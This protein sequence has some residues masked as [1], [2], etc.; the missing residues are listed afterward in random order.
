MRRLLALVA[1]LALISPTSVGAVDASSTSFYVRQNIHSISGGNSQYS[2]STSTSFQLVSA[3]GQTANGTS[4]VTT[5]Y[6]LRAGFLQSLFKSVQPIYAQTHYHWRLDNGTES[7]ATALVAEDTATTSVQFYVPQ[8]LRI[9]IANLGGTQT[10]FTE[11]QLGLE[12]AY[13]AAPCDDN[14]NNWFS[15]GVPGGSGD[16]WQATSSQLV[17]YANT[18]NISPSIGGV[19]DSNHTFIA[20][21]H[22]SLDADFISDITLSIPSDSFVEYE[23]SIAATELAAPGATYCFRLQDSSYPS[24]YRFDVYPEA[25]LVAG[26][27]NLP[28]ASAVSIDSGATSVTLTENTTKNVVCAGT[29]TDNDG[30]ADISTVGAFLYRTGVGTTSASDNN[31]LYRL[32]GDSQCVPSSGSGNSETYTCTFPVQYYADATD[33]GS[34][35]SADNWSCELHPRDAVATG[36]PATD[37]TEMASLMALNVSATIAY[38]SVDA[39]TDTGTT[40]QTTTVTNTGNRDMDPQLSGVNMTDGGSN[41]IAVGQ[42]KYADSAF[43]YSSGGAALTTT[44]TTFN[45]TLPQQTTDGGGGV[46]TDAVLWGLGVPNGTINTSYTGTNTFTATTGI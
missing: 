7:T 21:N 24:L 44:P 32:Y 16:E 26:G 3:G 18:T 13:K 35:N 28:I 5:S 31:N 25:T 22:G 42:Q 20:T 8:R 38:G 37:T 1:V 40:N 29:V 11:Q 36:T 41:T 33:A 19:T 4:T 9:Q 2:F 30:F 46:I 12:Y 10:Q 27:N 14:S 15:L 6:D 17:N 39:N 45:I 34:P 23:Y 43:T